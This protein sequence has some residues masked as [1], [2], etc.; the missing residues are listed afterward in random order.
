MWTSANIKSFIVNVWIIKILKIK[1]KLKRNEV[2]LN[3]I[4]NIAAQRLE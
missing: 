3:F 1:E 2:K 4:D